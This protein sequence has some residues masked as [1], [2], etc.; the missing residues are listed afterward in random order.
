MYATPDKVPNTVNIHE[1]KTNFSQLVNAAMHGKEIFIARAG[2][3]V[4]RLMPLRIDK[5]KVRFG[6]MKGKFKI[7]KDFDAPL[8][9]DI[10]TLFEGQ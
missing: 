3:P 9:D 8:P 5:P 4:A 10:I 6:A 2:K 7:P 1:A